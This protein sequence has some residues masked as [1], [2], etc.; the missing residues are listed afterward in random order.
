MQRFLASLAQLLVRRRRA[1]VTSVLV[2]TLALAAFIPRLA[3]D[4]SPEKLVASHDGQQAV[5]AEL[6]STFGD[7]DRVVVLLV[8]AQDVLRRAPLQYVHRLARHF[9]RDP[10]VAR[11]ESVT[12]TP[13]A[14]RA[15]VH[16]STLTLDDLDD[17]PAAPV[18]IE[19]ED[20]LA[21]LARA[22]PERYPRGLF[23]IAGQV[24]GMESGPLIDG[25]RVTDAD[26][27]RVRRALADAPLLEGRLVSRDRRVAA[28][29]LELAGSDQRAR[30]REVDRIERWIAAHPPPSGVRVDAG[31]L[32]VLRNALAE[33]IAA[34]QR[35]LLPITFIVCAVLLLA[36]LRWIGGVALSLATVGIAAA[37]VVGGMA[38]IG[39]PMNVLNEIVPPLL[40]IS[41]VSDAIHLVSRYREELRVTSDRLLAA[42]RTV[43]RLAV[44]CFFTSITTAVGLGSL[45]VSRTEMLRG[46]GL[47]AGIGVMLAYVVTIAF[48]PPTLTFLPAPPAL[49]GARGDRLER[50]I[51]TLTG[52]LLRHR[53]AVLA[54]SAIVV[55]YCAFAAAHVEIDTRLLDPF[56]ADA[57]AVVTTRLMER[58]LSGTRPLEVLLRA[59]D[60]AVFRDPDVLASIDDAAR[61]AERRPGVLGAMSATDPLHEVWSVIDDD[62]SV[63]DARFRSPAQVEALAT[64][65]AQSDRDPLRAFLSEDG[66]VLRM[67]VMLKDVGARASGDIIGG[68]REKLAS[69]LPRDVHVAMTGEAYVGSLA[70]ESVV[71]D[72]TGSLLVA[73]VIIFA[74]LAMLF[75]SLRLAL[76]SVPPSLTPLIVTAARMRWRGL[77]LDVATAIIFS[78]ALGL[79]VDGSIHVLARY[80]EELARR[81]SKDAALLA[82][83]C[84]TGRAIAVSCV[85]LSIGFGVLGASELVPV[86]QFGELIAVSVASCLVATLVILPPLISLVA[87]EPEAVRASD[88]VALETADTSR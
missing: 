31:G 41:G 37:M 24:E 44:A 52:G 27:A 71:D 54:C 58:E 67:Q 22:E 26:A 60:P 6:R 5:T 82:S 63:R 9:A 68:L 55:G 34:D 83:A 28:V 40:I 8:Q 35:V 49:G 30:A 46:F 4:P 75:R 14:R 78:I 18:S 79:A 88:G 48:L 13:L 74:M 25:D 85:T 64:L 2:V 16:A 76:A 17:E 73:V 57:P 21:T 38:A 81:R 56:D 61:W 77:S 11:V 51:A 72:L 86:R 62:P 20:A 1:W 59:E 53:R 80:R 47:L 12:T 69:A 7:S 15:P 65:L 33:G 32:P 50:M 3:T 43:R 23:S 10:A 70:L 39:Q 87:R 29:T 84:G 45:L 36:G 42:R 66:R 19:V